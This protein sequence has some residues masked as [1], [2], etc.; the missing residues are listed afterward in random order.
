VLTAAALVD[1][2]TATPETRVKIPARLAT[3]GRYI[4]DAFDHGEIRLN[5]RGVVALSSNIG[6][7][8]L[9]RQLTKQQLYDYLVRFGLGARTGIELPGESVGIAP[10]AD[11]SDSQRDQVAFGQAIAVTGIQQAAAV[12]GIINNGVYHPPTVIK[13]A[14][15]AEGR[16][17]PIER[18]PPRRVISPESSAHVRDLMGAVIDSENGQRNLKLDS[19]TTGGKTGTAQRADTTCRCYRGYVTSFIGFAPLDDPRVLTYIVISN[20]RAGSSGTAT[21]APVY[22]DLMN[23]ALPRYSVPPDAR[24]HNPKPTEW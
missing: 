1:S 15:D 6:T 7:A 13:R 18:R 8:L 12:A 14:T 16:E 23:F 11:M 5:L 22:R 24:P 4:S 21:A 19:Y 2:G 10:K 20:P 17:V 9:A 3:G